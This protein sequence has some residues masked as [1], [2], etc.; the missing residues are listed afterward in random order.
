MK[1]SQGKNERRSWGAGRRGRK[2]RK[3]E[4]EKEMTTDLESTGVKKT[5]LASLNLLDF[6]ISSQ[7]IIFANQAPF[8]FLF[9]LSPPA[10]M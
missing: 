3:K 6:P 9:S 8:L 5:G 2:K 1:E 4:G 10:N 7:L